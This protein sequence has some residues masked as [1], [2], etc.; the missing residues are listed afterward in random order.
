MTEGPAAVSVRSMPGLVVL[1]AETCGA[2]STIGLDPDAA[3]ALAAALLKHAQKAGASVTMI[4]TLNG[5]PIEG[6]RRSPVVSEDEA[7]DR[8]MRE[9]PEIFGETGRR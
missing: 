9:G 1:D 8:A 6:A 5:K 2:R 7:M 3:V 4:A